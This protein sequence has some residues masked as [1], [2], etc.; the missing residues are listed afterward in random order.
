MTKDEL[1]WIMVMG[2]QFNSLVKALGQH[3]KDTEDEQFR[4]VLTAMSAHAKR[5]VATVYHNYEGQM[6]EFLDSLENKHKT[7]R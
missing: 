1:Q 2:F 7:P 6:S 4:E 5:C 3:A